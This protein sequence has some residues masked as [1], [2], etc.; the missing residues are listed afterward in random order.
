[1]D[2]QNFIQALTSLPALPQAYHRCCYLLEQ[3]NTDS[4]TLAAVVAADPA[5]TISV[6][7]LVNSAFYKMPRKIER[8]DHAISIIGHQAFKSLIL[9][10]AVV[11]AVSHLAHGKVEIDIFWRHSIF[12]GLVARRL[13]LHSYMSNCERLFIAGLL[14]DIGQLIYFDIKPQKSLEVCDLVDKYDI[15]I[16]TAEQKILDFDHQMLGAELCK[17]WQLPAWLQQAI[18]HHHSPKLAPDY[19]EEASVIYLANLIAEEHY[20]GLSS[21]G[22]AHN[23]LADID[24]NDR[25]WRGINLSEDV[26]DTV[27][28]EAFEQFNEVVSLLVPSTKR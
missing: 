28:K 4:A 14:H 12:T 19:H 25:I 26:I 22:Q 18:R 8:L 15:E 7:R 23:R 21:Q 5:M 13:A 20:P 24:R 2:F 27:V 16:T 3:D 10:A 11:R 1:M 6:L 9:T 17:H